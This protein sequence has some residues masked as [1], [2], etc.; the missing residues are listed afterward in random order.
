MSHFVNTRAD[1]AI[2]PPPPYTAKLC[3]EAPKRVSATGWVA[4]ANTVDTLPGASDRA[5]SLG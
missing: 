2:L 1:H 4:R 5:D 3:F